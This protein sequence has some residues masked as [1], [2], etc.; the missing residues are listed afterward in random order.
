MSVIQAAPAAAV[1]LVTGGGVLGF[2]TDRGRGDPPDCGGALLRA[3]GGYVPF[4]W[5]AFKCVNA[6]KKGG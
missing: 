2:N 1:V 5:D 4:T 3:F 6:F